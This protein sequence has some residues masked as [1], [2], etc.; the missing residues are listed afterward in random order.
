MARK[1]GE[2]ERALRE[3]RETQMVE[4]SSFTRHSRMVRDA[5]GRGRRAFDDLAETLRECK[6]TASWREKYD[7]FAEACD[8]E[9]GIS[10]QHAHRLIQ[11]LAI[12]DFLGV[13]NGDKPSKRHEVEGP[14]A[15]PA[16]SLEN[17]VPL[18]AHTRELAKVP[19]EK[20]AEV[21]QTAVDETGGAPTARAVR[22]AAAAIT[23]PSEVVE[24]DVVDPV[25][26]WERCEREVLRL[27]AIVA[28]FDGDLHTA[29]AGLSLR[30][31]QLEAR[32]ADEARARREAERSA[33]YG[34]G[35][36]RK[37]REELGVERDREII[38]AI[39]D[40]RR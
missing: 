6:E 5:I 14:K 24:E 33:V 18:E 29:H 21:W 31:S 3:A 15:V 19:E 12:R 2:K 35:A 16:N 27:Q 25:E 32:L 8:L 34:T 17:A 20:R 13:T 22:E 36:L 10:R 23:P 39:R 4:E 7:S 11:G 1:I 40:L 37:I 26:E 28:D 30:Y 9:W 38:P